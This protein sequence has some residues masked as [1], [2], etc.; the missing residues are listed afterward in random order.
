HPHPEGAV[1]LAIVVA[2]DRLED[3][4][5]EPLEED[6]RQARGAREERALAPGDLVE[7]A[8]QPQEED[9]QRH[10]RE[11]GPAAAVRDEVDVR[12]VV[13]G[14]GLCHVGRPS[15][16]GQGAACGT[17][18]GAATAAVCARSVRASFLKKVYDSV[19]V[20]TSAGSAG[21]TMKRTG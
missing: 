6:Q 21:S 13:V 8:G 9:E 11:H 7:P 12:V 18:A 17:V 14:V 5:G 19:M 2:G 10:R 15:L 16:L 1:D 3:D 4:V 20:F